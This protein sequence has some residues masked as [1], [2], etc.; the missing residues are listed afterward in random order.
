MFPKKFHVMH[1]EVFDGQ[2][3]RLVLVK[4]SANSRLL[5]KAL[6]DQLFGHRQKW[7]VAAMTSARNPGR[8]WGFRR[9]HKHPAI[10]A[11]MGLAAMR[12]ARSGV[13]IIAGTGY[14]GHRPKSS[15]RSSFRGRRRR[16]KAPN[17]ADSHSTI[18]EKKKK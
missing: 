12:A 14:V 7:S 13:R 15:R 11:A 4:G 1:A 10:S 6:P 3:E 18:T 9:Q 8:L 17:F 16:S 5:S 2:K